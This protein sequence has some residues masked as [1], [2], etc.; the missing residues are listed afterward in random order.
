MEASS[1]NSIT[2][3]PVF[4][5]WTTFSLLKLNVIM[6][7]NKKRCFK[8]QYPWYK[9]VSFTVLILMRI[10][11]LTELK[12]NQKKQLDNKQKPLP[13]LEP[14]EEHSS[15]KHQRISYWNWCSNW[16]T[17]HQQL[18]YLN[19]QVLGHIPQR[20]KFC[21]LSSFSHTI[22]TLSRLQKQMLVLKM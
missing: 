19:D 20:R 9:R 5:L 7:N 21:I 13:Y 22:W 15:L 4:K 17:I 14:L 2:T 11:F 8:S 10:N 6:L 1:E 3:N 16:N 18:C 12:V